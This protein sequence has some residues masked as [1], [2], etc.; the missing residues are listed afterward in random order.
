MQRQYVY[1][2]LH[3]VSV[4]CLDRGSCF[5]FLDVIALRALTRDSIPGLAQGEGQGASAAQK[6]RMLGR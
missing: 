1:S 3:T 2:V 5:T 6:E 4:H